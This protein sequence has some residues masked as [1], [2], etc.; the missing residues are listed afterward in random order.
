MNGENSKLLNPKS[1]GQL[2][3]KVAREISPYWDERGFYVLYDHDPADKNVGKIMSRFG[4][5][6]GRRTQ[7]SHVDISIVEKNSDRVFALIEI[8]ETTNKPKTILGD[9][10]G[11]L[12]GEHIS[13]GK[14]RP[15]L[16]NEQTILVVFV[17]SKVSHDERNQYIREKVEK[18]KPE[19]GT[20]NSAIRKVFIETFSDDGK[21]PESVSSLLDNEFKRQL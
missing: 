20:K 16:V 2:T 5:S 18:V 1:H 12:M 8:E 15:L 11:V 6:Y 13:F 9:V 21:L 19:L 3:A 7:L 10:F 4:E 14:E 17:K